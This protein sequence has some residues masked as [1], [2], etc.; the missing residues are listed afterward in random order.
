MS[1]EST[2]TEP[3]IKATEKRPLKL[4]MPGKD[5]K[6]QRFQNGQRKEETSWRGE[7]CA[8][9]SV[10]HTTS[11][12][13]RE[14]ATGIPPDPHGKWEEGLRRCWWC[15][16][17]HRNSNHSWR[18]CYYRQEYFWGRQTTRNQWWE[19]WEKKNTRTQEEWEN[20]RQKEHRQQNEFAEGLRQN[21]AGTKRHLDAFN[22][23]G[24]QQR[25][26]TQI[27]QR[28]SPEPADQPAPTGEHVTLS[29]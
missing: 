15:S 2:L 19:N 27:W 8:L 5:R 10:K 14:N 12:D 26:P 21:Y 11:F 4:R 25:K 13:K 1:S 20:W 23:Q 28:V 16:H 24:E 3:E 6:Q 22:S 18:N 7:R 17:Q 9:T 29:L